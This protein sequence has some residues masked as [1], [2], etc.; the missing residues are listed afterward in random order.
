MWKVYLSNL[1]HQRSHTIFKMES[2]L[3]FI[4]FI[5]LNE[6]EQ[7]ASSFWLNKL[8]IVEFVLSKFKFGLR[9]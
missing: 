6:L 7:Y 1:Y 9:S 3:K 5:E 8:G 2:K 4:S